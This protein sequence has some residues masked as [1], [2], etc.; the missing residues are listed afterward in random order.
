[1]TVEITGQDLAMIAQE[2]GGTH[3]TPVEYEIHHDR[4]FA[5][6]TSSCCDN[7]EASQVACTLSRTINGIAGSF[8]TINID[9]GKLS[10]SVGVKPPWN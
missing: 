6:I 4:G 8:P 2:V 3:N 1:M 5:T 7:E 9:G 10:C